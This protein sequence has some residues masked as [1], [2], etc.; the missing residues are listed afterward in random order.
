MG[1]VVV[2]LPAEKKN[3]WPWKSQWANLRAFASK[4]K[5]IRQKEENIHTKGKLRIKKKKTLVDAV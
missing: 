1:G 5:I 4:L 2:W 3:K